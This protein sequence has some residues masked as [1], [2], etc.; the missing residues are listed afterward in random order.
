MK[1]YRYLNNPGVPVGERAEGKGN[2]LVQTRRK[3]EVYYHVYDDVDKFYVD[4]SRVHPSY[5]NYHEVITDGYQK[6]RLDID[7]RIP[8]RRKRKLLKVVVDLFSSFGVTGVTPVVY[9]II[10]SY[11]VVVP[12]VMFESAGCCAMISNLVSDKFPDM[13]ID[14]GVYKPVQMF[15]LEGSTK[16]L[17]NRWKYRE[18]TRELS[19]VSLFKSGLVGYTKG[20]KLVDT[21]V[22]VSHAL[23]SRV[24][25]PYIRTHRVPKSSTLPVDGTFAVRRNMGNMTLLDRYRP[26]YCDRCNRVHEH[27]NAYMVGNKFFCR[28]F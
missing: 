28:R 10:T 11:H 3:D 15:R 17:E 26:S 27:E 24:Y 6:F 14:L 1:R 23:F 25:I 8:D 4:Y 7:E 16:Y 13:D 20:C 5:R 22:V 19:P 9:D 2:F 12:D 21:D 18:G